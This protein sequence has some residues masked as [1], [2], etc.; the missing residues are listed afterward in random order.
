MALASTCLREA[1]TLPS[2]GRCFGRQATSA[3]L[4]S[5][6]SQGFAL[7]NYDGSIAYTPV[8]KIPREAATQATGSKK[9]VLDSNL[10]NSGCSEFL[11]FGLSFRGS[12]WNSL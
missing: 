8:F 4:Q 6:G 1:V 2:L 11:L 12:F 9:K 10:K 3:C 5:P 7:G